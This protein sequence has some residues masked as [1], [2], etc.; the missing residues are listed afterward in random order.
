MRA[1]AKGSRVW[2][3]I[4]DLSK[5]QDVL[6]LGQAVASDHGAIHTLINNAG[7]YEE[8]LAKSAEGFEMTYAV[9][10]L[11]PF[12]LTALLLDKVGLPSRPLGG[13]K[14]RRV[15]IW[16]RQRAAREG[17]RPMKACA[18]RSSRSWLPCGAPRPAS[19]GA[20]GRLSCPVGA[21]GSGP[22]AAIGPAPGHHHQQHLG[23]VQP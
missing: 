4:A 6:Q 1:A 15:A 10:V 12:L 8:W 20:G 14:R 13:G 19:G 21:S 16:E 23:S 22:L 2:S 5:R 17:L 11:A 3:Y 7:V 18:A 9:N